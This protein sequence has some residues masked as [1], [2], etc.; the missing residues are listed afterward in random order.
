M[1]GNNITTSIYSVE[2][3][4]WE[5]AFLTCLKVP[6]YDIFITFLFQERTLLIKMIKIELLLDACH[7]TYTEVQLSK[8]EKLVQNLIELHIFNAV[9]QLKS[10]KTISNIKKLTYPIIKIKT[11]DV[12]RKYSE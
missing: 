1:E 10:L 9:K 7:I 2:S 5:L 12:W 8:L 11:R 6:T 4:V 3:K